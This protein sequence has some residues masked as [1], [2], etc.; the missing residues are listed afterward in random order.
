MKMKNATTNLSKRKCLT[1]SHWKNRLGPLGLTAF[2]L[3]SF[4]TSA[5]AQWTLLPTS[6]SGVNLAGIQV[7]SQAWGRDGSGKVYE[8]IGGTFTLIDPADTPKFAHITV[9]IGA[10]PF[11]GIAEGTGE[12]YNYNGSTFVNVPLPSGET[13]DSIGASG[14]GIWAVNSTTGHVFKYQVSTNSWEP[15]AT[16]EPT[17]H[18]ESISAGNFAI[19]P[20]AIDNNGGAWLYNSRTGFFDGPIGGLPSGVSA[21]QVTVGHGQAWVLSSESSDNVYVYDDNPTVEKWFHPNP[22]AV[23]TLSEIAESTDESLW[24]VSAGKVY[25]FDTSTILFG[26]TA[27]PAESV[28]E[29]KVGT[30]GVFVLSSGTGHVYSFE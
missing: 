9:G 8:D 10:T 20:W 25:L 21:L 26:L 27:Q 28:F 2:F 5:S 22:F 4:A 11:W 12:T 15:P 16:G 13:F 19:G 24:G 30:A 23:P 18:F 1:A 7:G 3:C 17:E 6:P 14:E 29:V